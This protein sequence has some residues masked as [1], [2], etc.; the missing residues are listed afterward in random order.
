MA[1]KKAPK[2]NGHICFIPGR[3]KLASLMLVP[4]I[5]PLRASCPLWS[6][7]NESIWWN[8][9]YPN[10]SQLLCHNEND[11]I[12]NLLGKEP[13]LVHILSPDSEERPCE[14]CLVGILQLWDLFVLSVAK[15]S[16]FAHTIQKAQDANVELFNK[17]INALDSWLEN[18]RKISPRKVV[19]QSGTQLVTFMQVLTTGRSLK[20]LEVTL[21]LMENSLQENLGTQKLQFSLLLLK[22][23]SLFRI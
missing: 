16:T 8:F 10:Q 19:F 23:P 13:G 11:A 21:C 17:H 9:Q 18:V 14:E 4:T 3:V 2:R 22:S 1:E 6:L 12:D 7:P 15:L 20:D 5:L